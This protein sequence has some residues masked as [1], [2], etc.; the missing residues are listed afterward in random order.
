M[1]RIHRHTAMRVLAVPIALVITLADWLL[2]I[3][4]FPLLAIISMMPEPAAADP[5]QTAEWP[6]LPIAVA[7]VGVAAFVATHFW[8]WGFAS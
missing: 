2:I 3:T 5:E 7:L 4:S 1:I 8:P 6:L